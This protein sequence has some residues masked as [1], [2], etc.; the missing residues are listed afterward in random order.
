MTP[1]SSERPILVWPDVVLDLQDLLADVSIPVY[2]VGGAVRDAFLRRPIKDVDMATPD[3]GI[4]LGRIIAN[5]LGGDFFPLD[6]ERDV[7]RAL[8]DTPDGRL[9]FDVA[10]LRGPDL[11]A[12]LFDRDFTIN[13]MAVDLHG[14]L[15]ELIDPTGGVSDAIAK[16]IRRCSPASLADDPIRA[17]RAVRQSVQFGMR[18]DPATLADV[19]AVTPRLA[20]ISAERVRDEVFKLLALPRPV[21]ALRVANTVGLLDVTLP[22]VV[23]LRGRKHTPQDAD[24]LWGYTLAVIERLTDI[25]ATLSPNRSDT[26]T[27]QFSMGM[28]AIALDR[29]RSGLRA[30]LAVEWP[31]ERSHRAVLLF[32]ALLH[33]PVIGADQAVARAAALH[34]SNG[35]K[36]RVGAVARH[37]GDFA[38]LQDLDEL[39]PLT[40]HRFWRATGAAGV[41]V[42]LLGLAGYLATVGLAF[43][44]DA[45]LATLERAQTLLAAYFDAYDRLIEP[46]PLLRGTDLIETLNLKPGPIIGELIDLIREGQ[47]VGTVETVADALALARAHLSGQRDE[48]NS[49]HRS[50]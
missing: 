4:K 43:T 29:F 10:S 31:D 39:T 15:N 21:M 9:V 5:R 32:A 18:I 26:S 6:A 17:L 36:D 24:D 20:E 11:D 40:I 50:E 38:A 35:E 14:D 37:A 16:R 34:L 25:L 30:Q 49:H 23:P 13:A 8:V 45:W 33:H 7:G 46:P 48:R 19:R 12:D 47:A 22:E 42:I 27:A 44:Q 3:S 1:P 2:I 28:L 41:D